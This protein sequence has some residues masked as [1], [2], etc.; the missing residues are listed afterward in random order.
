MNCDDFRARLHAF[1]ADTL[2]EAR[3]RDLERHAAGCAA[4]GRLFALA[5]ELS[6]REFVEFL[7]DYV[8]GRLPAERRAVFERHIVLC[9]DCAKYLDGY[10][11]TLSAARMALRGD[12]SALSD[13][14]LPEDLIRAILAAREA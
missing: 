5:Q 2:D 4:C 12:E 14:A 3:R 6:C 7:D 9:G 8:E 11:K 10:R 1:F 13:A